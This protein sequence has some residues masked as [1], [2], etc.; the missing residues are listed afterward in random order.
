M[1]NE[2]FENLLAFK[3]FEIKMRILSSET[4]NADAELKK[5]GGEKRKERKIEGKIVKENNKDSKLSNE[6]NNGDEEVE[7]KEGEDNE[8]KK[9]KD[10]QLVKENKKDAKS[11]NE[12]NN[13]DE[14]DKEN[15]KIAENEELVKEKE[16]KSAG[17]KN[18]KNENEKVKCTLCNQFF[19]KKG[20][21]AHV[22]RKHGNM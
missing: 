19:F 17:D 13:G 18:E 4:Q 11:S 3:S 12:T 8:E 16:Q 7:T 5:I 15:K 14:G 20:I 1:I 21:K 9:L 22:T 6:T 10:H 2:E